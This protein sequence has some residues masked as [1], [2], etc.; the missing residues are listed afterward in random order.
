MTHTFHFL[1]DGK[2]GSFSR[3]LLLVKSNKQAFWDKVRLEKGRREN[4][5]PHLD[6]QVQ[7]EGNNRFTS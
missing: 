6:S 3:D 7:A 2:S 4:Q 1:Q 5:V